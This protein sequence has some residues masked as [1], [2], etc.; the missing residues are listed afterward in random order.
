M[1]HVSKRDPAACGSAGHALWRNRPPMCTKVHKDTCWKVRA[2]ECVRGLTCW[3]ILSHFHSTTFKCRG[4]AY[5]TSIHS[6][7]VQSGAPQRVCASFRTH[8][9]RVRSLPVPLKEKANKVAQF[10]R[11]WRLS[12]RQQLPKLQAMTNTK[13]WGQVNIKLLQSYLGQKWVWR[14]GG[15]GLFI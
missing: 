6:A 13:Q 1:L 10:Q 14:R 4:A 11:Y 9:F 2:S 5:Y 15:G 12:G 7:C 8:K 3:S